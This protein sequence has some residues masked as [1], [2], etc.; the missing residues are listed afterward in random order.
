MAPICCAPK[1]ARYT[2]PLWLYVSLT[3]VVVFFFL[4]AYE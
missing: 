1:I 4:K 3:G 2:L